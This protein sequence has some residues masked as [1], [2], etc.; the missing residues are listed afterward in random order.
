MYTHSKP[1]PAIIFAESASVAPSATV[2]LPL[3]MSSRRRERRWRQAFK[4]NLY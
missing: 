3:A 2:V 1:W 4:T